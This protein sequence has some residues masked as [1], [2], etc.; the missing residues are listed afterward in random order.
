MKKIFVALMLILPLTSCEEY[1]R[2]VKIQQEF[3]NFV[4]EYEVIA[5]VLRLENIISYSPWTNII[6]PE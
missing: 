5:R 4:D 2:Q 1:Q 6:I 3:D